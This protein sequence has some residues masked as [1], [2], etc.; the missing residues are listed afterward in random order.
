M[1][2]QPARS[3]QPPSR[4]VRGIALAGVPLGVLFG[5]LALAATAAL[6]YNLIAGGG[7]H[8]ILLAASEAAFLGSIAYSVGV[9]VPKNVRAWDAAVTERE[10]L[11]PSSR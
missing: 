10:E 11:G 8:R 9:E 2:A 6:I 3:P 5:L 1:S 4:F 7:V